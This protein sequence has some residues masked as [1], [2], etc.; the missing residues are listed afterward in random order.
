MHTDDKA[1]IQ[2]SRHDDVAVMTFRGACVSDVEEIADISRQITEFIQEHHPKRL[3]VDFA[4]VKFFSSQVLGLLLDCRAKLEGHAGEVVLASLNPQL[5]RVFRIT[6][7][8]KIFRFF[9][10]RAAAVSAENK[11]PSS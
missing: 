11:P 9:P 2:I 1:G 5:H 8:D 3:V 10:D 6:N 7:L 4:N